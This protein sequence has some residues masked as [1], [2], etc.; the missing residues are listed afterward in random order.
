MSKKIINYDDTSLFSR[1]TVSRNFVRGSVH[2][3]SSGWTPNIATFVRIIVTALE[4]FKSI[5]RPYRH[6]KSS[7]RRLASGPLSCSAF[8]FNP[9]DNLA[10]SV[11]FV[12]VGIPETGSEDVVI[13]AKLGFIIEAG[14]AVVG[15]AE[16]I[17]AWAWGSGVPVSTL[18]P[19][20]APA[21]ST[22]ALC[23]FFFPFLSILFLDSCGVSRNSVT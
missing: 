4:E 12:G 23:S 9:I 18:D 14:S 20:P 19:D 10:R 13:R 17:A 6:R 22:A 11:T 5:H 21:P 15:E 3:R 2:I 1:K 8:R 7:Q 16:N